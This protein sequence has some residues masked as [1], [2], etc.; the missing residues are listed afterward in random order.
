LRVFVEN[1]LEAKWSP[2]E[3]CGRLPVEF[4]D[5]DSMRVVHETIIRPCSCKAVAD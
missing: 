2:E 4:P 5:D 3:I 1:G